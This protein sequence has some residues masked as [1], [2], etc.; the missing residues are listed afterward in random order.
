MAVE[1]EISSDVATIKDVA[2][3]T[4]VARVVSLYSGQITYDDEAGSKFA[5]ATIDGKS[6]RVMLCIAVNGFYRLLA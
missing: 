2:P 3:N 4:Q 5:T 1:Y 6:Q